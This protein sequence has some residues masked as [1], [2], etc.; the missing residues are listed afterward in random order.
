MSV[1][2]HFLAAA[3]VTLV[4]ASPAVRHRAKDLG[5]DLAEVRPA[6]GGRIRHADLDAF[7]SYGG[8]KGYAPAGPTGRDE[9][10]KVVGLRRRIAENMAA[11]KR[12]IPHF[13]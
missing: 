2:S 10:I 1:R 7:L 4:L 3:A 9:T 13:S 11:S 5:I 8:T 12:Q 6:E